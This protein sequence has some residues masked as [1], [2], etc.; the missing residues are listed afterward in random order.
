MGIGGDIHRASTARLRTRLICAVGVAGAC[1]TQDTTAPVADRN[2]QVARDVRT[3]A[4]TYTTLVLTGYNYPK[5]GSARAINASGVIT[6]WHRVATHLGSPKKRA[7][8]YANLALTSIPAVSGYVECEGTGVSTSGTIV[9]SCKNGGF[10]VGFSWT[11]AGGVVKLTSQVQ[12][13]TWAHAISPAGTVVGAFVALDNRIH[14]AKWTGTSSVVD[15]HPAGADSSRA[16]AVNDAGD[17]AINA[18]Y[19]GVMRARRIIGGSVF[20]P[21]ALAPAIAGGHTIAGGINAAGL[22]S[23]NAGVGGPNS[24][25]AIWSAIAPPIWFAASNPTVGWGISNKQRVVGQQGNYPGYGAAFT[26]DAQGNISFLSA[27]GAETS[28][29]AV[30]TCG[31]IV[32]EAKAPASAFPEAVFWFPSSCDP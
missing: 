13:A 21:I 26:R 5:G 25:G 20:G 8:R 3:T 18:W 11:Q 19:A 10:N 29:F 15:L 17:V 4:I 27:P 2:L 16:V 6:G 14:A 32:G 7:F 24:I 9:G 28:A 22:I 1:S 30:N 31:W 12:A 23:G